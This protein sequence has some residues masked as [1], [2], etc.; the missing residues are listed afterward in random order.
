VSSPLEFPG[1]IE[2]LPEPLECF[3]SGFFCCFSVLAVALT[4]ALSDLLATL[5]A[6]RS[7]FTDLLTLFAEDTAAAVDSALVAAAELDAVGT[8]TAGRVLVSEGIS[9]S[10]NGEADL[11]SD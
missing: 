1:I 7:D 2:P 4:D 9:S 11:A 5:L 6:C 3:L 10:G 8:T